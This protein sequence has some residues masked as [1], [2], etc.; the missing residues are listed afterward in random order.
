M[1]TERKIYVNNDLDIVTARLQAREMAR[2]MG[3]G[4][5]DQ[6]RISLATSELA[7]VLSWNTDRCSEIV[8]TN[9][10]KNGYHGVQVACI[11]DL[12]HIEPPQRSQDVSIPC[13]SL[14]GARQL[15]DESIVEALDDK[16][17]RVTLCQ[18][19]K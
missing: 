10:R 7:R 12:E 5:A 11:I 13:R 19:F 2:E 15:V 14:S 8:I 9:A 4:T 1:S 3:F 17:A 6:A 16:L 18:W